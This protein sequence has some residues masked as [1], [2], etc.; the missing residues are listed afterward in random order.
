M[1]WNPKFDKQTTVYPFSL[2]AL[3]AWLEKQP[4]GDKYNHRCAGHCLLAQYFAAVGFTNVRLGWRLIA[5]DQFAGRS[6]PED[7]QLVAYTAPHTF[8]AALARARAART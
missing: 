3:I 1:L 4:E 2:E 6:V 5:S 7:F 8:G